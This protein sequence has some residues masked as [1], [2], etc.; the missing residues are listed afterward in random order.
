MQLLPKGVYHV[1]IRS[2]SIDDY[3]PAHTVW[4]PYAVAPTIVKQSMDYKLPGGKLNPCLS[5]V[6]S[7][8]ILKSESGY[9]KFYVLAAVPPN[10]SAASFSPTPATAL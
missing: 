8:M 3:I 4:S 5:I 1:S 7:V 9:L 10:G 2:I 6:Y